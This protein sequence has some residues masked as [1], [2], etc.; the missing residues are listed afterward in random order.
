MYQ[1]KSIS[2][3]N[4]TDEVSSRN[5]YGSERSLLS[6]GQMS[7]DLKSSLGLVLAMDWTVYGCPL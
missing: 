5:V 4:N 3:V 2:V 6:L 1:R 7:W